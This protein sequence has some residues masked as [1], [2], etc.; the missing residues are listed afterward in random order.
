MRSRSSDFTLSTK[1]ARPIS[2]DAKLDCAGGELLALVG[3]SGSGKSTLLR[4]IAGLVRPA[5][6][7]IV[8]GS[9]VWFDHEAGINQSPQRRRVGFVPQHY[10]LFP[11]MTA[12]R[13]VMAGLHDVPSAR[14]E[15]RARCW[16]EKVHLNGLEGRRPAELS[17]G[18]QQRVA[19]ARALVRE[20]T[21]LLLDEPFSAVDRV[22]RESLYVELAELKRDLAVPAIMVT[23]DLKEAMLLADRMTLLAHGRTLQSGEPR[24]VVAKPC[25]EASARLLG[26]LNIFK[27]EILRHDEPNGLSWIRTGDLEL[28]FPLAPRWHRGDSIGWTI[29]TEGVRLRA[30]ISGDLPASCNQ[31]CVEIA[32]VLPMGDHARI[33]ARLPGTDTPL[34][35]HAAPSMVEKLRLR[36]GVRTDVV[37][38]ES[39]LHVF[40]PGIDQGRQ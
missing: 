11:H 26:A 25:C 31:V 24:E 40:L 17:G 21:I 9:D 18:Q 29:P 5:T 33:T 6:G 2:L 27:G 8:Y 14:R 34:Y 1:L 39:Q 37:L 7:R 32:N 22:T 13:N 28:A 19:L 23:H 16:M 35:L 4:Q 38:R 3:P 10:G 30:R 36:P 12:L 20:P 15:E